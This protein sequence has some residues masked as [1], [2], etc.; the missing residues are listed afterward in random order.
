MK[1][2]RTKKE[3]IQRPKATFRDFMKVLVF[4]LKATFLGYGGGNALMP[5][6]RKFAVIEQGWLDDEEFDDVVI[7]SNMIP[8]PSVVEALSYV[9][10]KKL[11][12]FWGV[13]V[14]LIGIL[15]HMLLAFGLYILSTQYLPAKYLWILNVAIMPIIIAILILF[16]I[17]Y[18]KQS[19]KELSLPVMIVLIISS[20]LFC[21][22]VPAPFNVP[23]ILMIGTIL[24]VFVVEFIRI[25]KKQK[26]DLK[27]KVNEEG[28]DVQIIHTKKE[29][30]KGGK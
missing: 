5:I 22:F 16:V 13:V 26:E 10:I 30:D 9:A 2:N 8:G 15:P 1:K 7:A 28:D 14:A 18:V 12:K 29:D 20:F 19:R 25:R 6:I 4:I 3:K 21:M 27:A 24:I 17:R 23:A 11:G